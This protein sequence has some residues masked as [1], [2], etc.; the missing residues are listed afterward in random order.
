MIKQTYDLMCKN[1]QIIKNFN[2]TRH[3][4]HLEPDDS[5]VIGS[6]HHQLTIADN[7]PVNIY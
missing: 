6:F 2:K 4:L 5:A 7:S 3:V 1:N